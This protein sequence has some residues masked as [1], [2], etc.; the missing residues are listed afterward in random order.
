MVSP[1]RRTLPV[2]SSHVFQRVKTAVIS[3]RRSDGA[4]QFYVRESARALAWLRKHGLIVQAGLL[5]QQA[6]LGNADLFKRI[7]RDLAASRFLQ[8]NN[9]APMVGLRFHL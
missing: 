1:A 7:D 5:C 8:R 4:N 6:A 9:L 2:A 3:R